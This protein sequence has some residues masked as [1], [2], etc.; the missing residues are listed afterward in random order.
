VLEGRS[1]IFSLRD[2]KGKPH[3]TIETKPGRPAVGNPEKYVKFSELTPDQMSQFDE[4]SKAMGNDPNHFRKLED[5]H[6][7]N[8][9]SGTIVRVGE[10]QPPP[11]IH[12]IKSYS[13]K[14]PLAEHLPYVQDFVRS[15]KWSDVGDIENAGLHRTRDVLNDLERE[16]L[17]G[18]GHDFGDYM[19]LEERQGLQKMWDEGRAKGRE[20]FAQGGLVQH[21]YN[22]A[23]I[24]ARA[25][26]LLEELEF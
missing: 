14:A 8:P 11:S 23:A 21:Q 17:R 7:F 26:Q 1:R 22:P 9:E 16:T 13:N 24:D 2:A 5:T 19:T 6:L 15:G 12:Q 25:A 4:Y 3:V 10:V 18:Y 20:G